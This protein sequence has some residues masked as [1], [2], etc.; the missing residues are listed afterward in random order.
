MKAIFIELPHFERHREQHLDDESY[1]LLQNELIE[2]PAKGALIKGLGGL[3]KIRVA[4]TGRGKGKRGGS[5]VIYYWFV[6]SAHFVMFSIYG[7][8]VQDD[9]TSEQR[10][11]FIKLLSKLKENDYEI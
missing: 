8:E 3:R 6:D 10:K 9:L 5:R 7:K 11:Q 2:N 4:N 1:R